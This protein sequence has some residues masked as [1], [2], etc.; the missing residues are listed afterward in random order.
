MI[1]ECRRKLKK[2]DRNPAN[3]RQADI[4]MTTARVRQPFYLYSLLD[5]SK[6]PHELGFIASELSLDVYF[7]HLSEAMMTQRGWIAEE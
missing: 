5:V 3:P 7:Y 4:V 6:V 2:R 1:T